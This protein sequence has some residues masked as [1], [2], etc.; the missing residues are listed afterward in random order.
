M[1]SSYDN[2]TQQSPVADAVQSAKD[3][4][5]QVAQQ[6]KEVAGQAIDN[7]RGQVKTAFTSQKDRAATS[8]THVADAFRQTGQQLEQQGHPHISQYVETAAEQVSN[9]SSYLNEKSMDD[10]MVEAE[11]FA[12]REPVWFVGGAL[13]L[14]IMA[15]RFLKSSAPSMSSNYP[16][17]ASAPSSVPGSYPQAA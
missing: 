10:L 12:R 17:A 13:A 16:Q 11:D 14:G 15:G 2:T 8:L 3:Q 4:A 9:I 6:G 5:S 1:E 7:A